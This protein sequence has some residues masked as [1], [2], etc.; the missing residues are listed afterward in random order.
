ME[1]RRVVDHVGYFFSLREVSVL[2]PVFRLNMMYTNIQWQI[3][4]P[5]EQSITA[6]GYL[7]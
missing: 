3:V 4:C 2:D 1:S 5:S 6:F 7:I